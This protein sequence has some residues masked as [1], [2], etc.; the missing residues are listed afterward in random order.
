MSSPSSNTR[1]SNV[2]EPKL[3]NHIVDMLMLLR[4]RSGTLLKQFLSEGVILVELSWGSYY[5]LEIFIVQPLF[6]STFNAL[7]AGHAESSFPDCL[8][9]QTLARRLERVPG[10]PQLIFP[11]SSLIRS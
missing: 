8:V 10:D 6:G 11:D 2:G 4:P 1:I 5:D 3:V 7:L 9:L